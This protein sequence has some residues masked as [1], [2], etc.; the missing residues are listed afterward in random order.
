MPY[1]EQGQNLNSQ[2]STAIAAP[3]LPIESQDHNEPRVTFNQQ[4]LS[5]HLSTQEGG[6][7]DHLVGEYVDSYMRYFAIEI[8]YF[9]IKKH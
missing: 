6:G 2:F 8:N 5:R 7:G 9:A 4:S 3:I 1:H